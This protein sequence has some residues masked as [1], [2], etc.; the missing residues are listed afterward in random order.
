MASSEL[1][2]RFRKLHSRGEPLLIPNPWDVGSARILANL[3]FE[4]LATTSSGYAMTLGR[5]DGTVTK[6][7]TLAYAASIVIATSLPVTADLENGFADAPE[8]VAALVRQAAE[9]GLAGCSIEDHTGRDD[10]PIYEPLRAAERIAAAA[11]AAHAGVHQLVL[12][13]RAENFLHGRPDLN[14]TISRLQAFQDAGADVLYAPGVRELA[15]MAE[16]V[17]AVDRPVNALLLP[18]GPGVAELGDVGVKRISVGGMFA[19][20]AAAAVLEAGH[21]LLSG[22]T[23]FMT[24]AAIGREAIGQSFPR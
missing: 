21:D 9:M 1:T 15:Q 12:T 11:E 4:A 10:E 17:R 2:E 16:I 20:A 8:E 6:A 23:D 13:A 19:Y 7:E 5:L 18:G 14:D 3:G 24:R 22:R